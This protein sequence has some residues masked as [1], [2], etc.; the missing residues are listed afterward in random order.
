MTTLGELFAGYGGT[1]LALRTLDP[2]IETRWVSEIEPAACTTLD[3]RLNAPN[4]GDITA[5]AWAD[6]EKVDVLTGGFP[7]QDASQAGKRKGIAHGTRSGLWLIMREAIAALTPPVVII[8]NVKGLLSVA[9]ASDMERG[10]GRLGGG[11]GGPVLRGAGRVLGDLASLGY[12]AQ[13]VTL[14]A[15]MVGAPHQRERVF[16]LAHRPGSADAARILSV[17]ASGSRRGGGRPSDGSLP[18]PV[19]LLP[20][21]AVNDMGRGYE[22]D[23][24]DEWVARQKAA[25]GNGNGHGKSL[26]IEVRRGEAVFAQYAPAIRRWEQATGRTA[27]DPTE[28]G[29]RTE[30]HLS[31][32]FVEWMMGLPDG[33]VTGEDIGLSRNAQ[34]KM[35]GNGVVPQQAAAAVTSLSQWAVTA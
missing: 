6:V 14:P 20:T 27:P 15:S 13:W 19:T 4:I 8:E 35:L 16:I 2:T 7:C 24:W 29:D 17:W 3:A 25:H 23:A 30:R 22:P 9:A 12:D 34:I 18:A 31:A 32:R 33:W 21:P 10:Q 11:A 28:G 1:S 26:S 5:V